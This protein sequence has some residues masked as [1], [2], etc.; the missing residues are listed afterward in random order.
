M[1]PVKTVKQTTKPQTF[2]S[3]LTVCC[4]ASGSNWE[5]EAVDTGVFA[6]CEEGRGAR[7]RS[8]RPV[9]T[10]ARAWMPG[11]TGVVAEGEKMLRLVLPNDTLPQH[12]RQ[13]RRSHGIAAAEAHNKRCRADAG[14]AEEPFSGAGEPSA[15]AQREPQAA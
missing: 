15:Q 6:L 4:T 12:V 7:R 5:K 8:S 11:G 2:S 10:A 1:R 13:I 9:P 3:A 14:D